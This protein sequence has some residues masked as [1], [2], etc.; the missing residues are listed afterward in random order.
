MSPVVV[1]LLLASALF[2]WNMGSHYS[3]AVMGMAYGSRALTVKQAT[4]L[5]AVFA[6]LGTVVASSGVVHTYAFSIVGSATPIQLASA[7]LGAS[8]AILVSTTLRLPASTIQVYTFSLL[9]VG[10]VSGVKLLYTGIYLVLSM[11]VLLP[12][13][14]ML[15]AYVL[16]PVVSRRFTGE[17]NGLRKTILVASLFSSFSLGSNDI[18]NAISSLVKLNVLT[19]IGPFVFG[20][21]FLALGLVTWGQRLIRRIGNEVV[22]VDPPLAAAVQLTQAATIITGNLMGYNASINQTIVA[23]LYGAKHSTKSPVAAP[24]IFRSIA[25]N[26]I[27]SLLISATF[28]LFFLFILSLAFGSIR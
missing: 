17:G 9:F 11:W 28:S 23:S 24:R 19:G 7:L 27:V 26:W 5:A 2:A 25:L 6:F 10:A 20:G 4:G 15:L 14:A 13:A 16:A 12:V 1:I 8:V 3:G 22:K 18:S 21:C